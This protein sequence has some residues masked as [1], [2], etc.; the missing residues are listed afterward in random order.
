MEALKLD[1][2]APIRSKV[3]TA[4]TTNAHLP[5]WETLLEFALEKAV[6]GD[7]VDRLLALRSHPREWFMRTGRAVA[8][9]MLRDPSL[10]K[11]IGASWTDVVELVAT[12]VAENQWIEAHKGLDAADMR[13]ALATHLPCTLW[14]IGRRMQI[15]R[16]L[17]TPD[18]PIL[19]LGDEH[20]MSLHLG[21][22][23]FRNV[24]VVDHD[25]ATLAAIARVARRERR[26]IILSNHDFRQTT[27]SA[28]SRDFS[29]VFADPCYDPVALK[30]TLAAA[31][32]VTANEPDPHVFLSVN[33]MSLLRRGM[34]ELAV[35]IVREGFRC[36]AFY[37][38]FNA[39]PIGVRH[40]ALLSIVNHALVRAP[41]PLHSSLQFSFFTSDGIL[42]KK[43][44][45]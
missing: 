45:D 32:L 10:R 14:S 37:P 29:L 18:D 33:V 6:D 24:T 2:I 3:V 34:A 43:R 17:A 25:M 31:A 22:A 40:R 36:D 21:R 8:D 44:H 16:A 38:A 39:Y 12:Q 19:L 42:L 35:G 20:M 30:Q 27:P 28:L 41:L 4:V 1:S 13:S 15:A 5:S 7:A 23:G 26:T 9:I 11:F